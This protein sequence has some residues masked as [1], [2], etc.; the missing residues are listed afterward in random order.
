M[1]KVF[2]WVGIFA[3][4]SAGSLSAQQDDEKQIKELIEKLGDDSFD[5]REKAMDE[6][7]GIGGKAKKFLEDAKNH[8]DPEVRWRA[9]RLLE[10]IPT[11]ERLG[12]KLL[13]KIPATVKDLANEGNFMKRLEILENLYDDEKQREKLSVDELNLLAGEVIRD[14]KVDDLKDMIDIVAEANV[15][16]KSTRMV[17]VKMLEHRD[18]DCRLLGAMYL[19]LI[20]TKEELPALEERLKKEKEEDVLKYVEGTIKKIRARIEEGKGQKEEEE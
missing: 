16:P 20:G 3:V 19:N 18:K 1:K 7:F 15:L 6:L 10:I 4:V 11:R 8:K 12:D 5:V 14:S 2:L 9:E 13:E 17:V